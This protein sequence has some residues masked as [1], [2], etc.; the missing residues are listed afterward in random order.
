MNRALAAGVLS[1][2]LAGCAGGPP[3]P[4]AI[5]T[6]NDACSW[7]RMGISDLRV[8]AQLVAPSEEPR[9]FDDIGCLRDY[10]AGGAAIPPGAIA[11]VADHQSRAWVVAARAIYSRTDALST[12]MDSHLA[13]WAD[14]A[15]RSADPLA[16]PENFASAK[17]IFGTPGPPEGMR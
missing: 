10:L 7:C 11:F 16:T 3:E 15:S 14:E 2:L 1:A 5:D 17:E 4:A 12:P 13:A 6:R 9:L 8:A